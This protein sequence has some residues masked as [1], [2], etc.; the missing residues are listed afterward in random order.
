[1]ALSRKTKGALGSE[2]EKPRV[3]LGATY[4]IRGWKG[5][6]AMELRVKE[7]VYEE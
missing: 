6:S 5:L 2:E 1:M 7:E 3:C 4:E